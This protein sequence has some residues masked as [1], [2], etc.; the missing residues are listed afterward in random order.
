[1]SANTDAAGERVTSEDPPLVNVSFAGVHDVDDKD[2]APSHIPFF[3]SP[4]YATPCDHYS[5]LV[6]HGSSIHFSVLF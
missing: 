2:A 6:V 1:M 5:E 3:L 4:E